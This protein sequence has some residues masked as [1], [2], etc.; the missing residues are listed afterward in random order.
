MTAYIVK[1][2]T[3]YCNISVN[4]CSRIDKSMISFY[5]LTFVI[6]GSITYRVDGQ[7][8][9]LEKNDAILLPPG[10]MR[11]RLQG[12]EKVQYVSLNFHIFPD[13]HLSLPVFMKNVI[14]QDIRALLNVFSQSHILPLYHSKEKLC[15]ILNYILFEIFDA[16]SFEGDHPDVIRIEKF[17]GENITKKITLQMI[18][19]YV[20]LSKEY[21]ACLFK[22]N[23]GKTVIEYVNERKMLLAKNMIQT[24][25]M[26]LNNVAQNLG[27]ENY[28][29]FSRLFSKHFNTSPTCFKYSQKV[30][31]KT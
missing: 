30:E 3:H 6:K 23:V 1:D 27:Y 7:E 28:S 15:N 17:I 16:L 5:D 2:I 24:G 29:Y 21:V 19:D 13:C 8:Y 31:L 14:T 9:V 20:H 25:E 11:Q 10:T 12:T 4:K 18:A 22:K 26:S